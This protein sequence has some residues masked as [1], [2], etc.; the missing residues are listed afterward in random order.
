MTD[1]A[2]FKDV[3]DSEAIKSAQ[4]AGRSQDNM[5]DQIRVDN[6]LLYVLD[7]AEVCGED[8]PTVTFPGLKKNEMREFGEYLTKRLVLE[9]WDR[10]FGEN[11]DRQ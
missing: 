4:A 8:Y 10:L 1:F 9:A 2:C 6:E 7:P 5:E 11:R 3:I